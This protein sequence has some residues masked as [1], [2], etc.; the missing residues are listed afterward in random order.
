[1]KAEIRRASK[2]RG[3][4][5][6]RK[7]KEALATK[8]EGKLLDLF[9][10]LTSEQQDKLIAFAEFLTAGAQE[11]PV[12]VEPV[13]IPRPATETVTMAI[14]RLAKSY[15]MLDR[16]DLMGEASQLLAQHALE[17]RPSTAVIDDL[18]LLFSRS[19]EQHKAKVG[20]R[21]AKG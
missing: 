2:A 4:S 6:R 8:G 21:K 14:R 1:M 3:R 18:E 16:R 9:D 15:P 11:G 7:A 10:Q 13:A 19:F 5:E 20:R 12:A 17:G